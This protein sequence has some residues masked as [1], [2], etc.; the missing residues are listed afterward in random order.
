M[1]RNFKLTEEE[2]REILESHKSHGY[3]TVLNENM[4]RIDFD[5]KSVE[6]LTRLGFKIHKRYGAMKPSKQKGKNIRVLPLPP[7]NCP[8][9]GQGIRIELVS[10]RAMPESISGQVTQ[11]LNPND[12]CPDSCWTVLEKIAGS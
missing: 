2:K 8:G 9:G 6:E 4:G 7:A 12:L 5:E 1:Y 11:L 3:K 10:A